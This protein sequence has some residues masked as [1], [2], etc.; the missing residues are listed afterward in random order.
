MENRQ[1]GAD[2]CKEPEESDEAWEARQIEDTFAI[3][4]KLAR[5][6]YSSD[7]RQQHDEQRS[8]RH[9][10]GLPSPRGWIPAVCDLD[11]DTVIL[12]T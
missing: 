9:P 5:A 8:L 7:G 10:R 11:I 12:Q 2:E 4:R 6:P 1:N 3:C